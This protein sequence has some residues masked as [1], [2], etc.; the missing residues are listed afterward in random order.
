MKTVFPRQKDVNPF[1]SVLPNRHGSSD[2]YRYGFQ[3]QEKDDEIKGEGNS[4]NFT[5]RMYDPRVG[6]FFTPDPL[7]DKYPWYTPYSFAG[8]KVIQYKELEG[9]EE[10]IAQ[11]DDESRMPA[12]STVNG[13][14]IMLKLFK[15]AIKQGQQYASNASYQFAFS[16]L[17][18]GWKMGDN[19]TKY[20]VFT[21]RNSHNL[22]VVEDMIDGK[23]VKYNLAVANKGNQHFSTSNV[24][25]HVD[26]FKSKGWEKTSKILGKA[27]GILKITSYASFMTDAMDG[28]A[29]GLMDTAL[30]YATG[31]PFVS[32]VTSE[33]RKI[34]MS[35]INDTKMYLD[36]VLT[37]GMTSKGMQTTSTYVSM[38]QQAQRTSFFDDFQVLRVPT[39]IVA[40]YLAGDIK[41]YSQMKDLIFTAIE[42]GEE[43]NSG[44]LMQFTDDNVI[45][46]HIFIDD[47]NSKPANSND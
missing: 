46:R 1:G 2:S 42:N 17:N 24:R 19:G 43:E 39:S 18:D 14:K 15:Y 27:D 44:F 40:S 29:N 6:R 31:N 37:E 38:Q 33:A 9:L 8:N 36:R 35:S 32:L 10:L 28:D 47:S 45:I 4:L 23:P 12:M 21:L 34:T 22:K 25:N 30:S 16:K 20:N 11:I 26:G 41:D 7:T 13:E 3:G 5:F